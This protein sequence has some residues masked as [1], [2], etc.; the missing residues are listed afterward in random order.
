MTTNASATSA[1]DVSAYEHIYRY[2]SAHYKYWVE[3]NANNQIIGG[4][5]VSTDRP[6]YVWMKN[7]MEFMGEFAGLR[8]IYRP[9]FNR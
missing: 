6:D 9:M 8:S 1:V 7:R 2:E 3:L 4:E 5:W